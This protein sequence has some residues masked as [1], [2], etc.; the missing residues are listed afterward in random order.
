LYD[1]AGKPFGGV[2]FGTPAQVK[3]IEGW[4]LDHM[5][6]RRPLGMTDRDK[7][8]GAWNVASIKFVAKGGLVENQPK[9]LKC[10]FREDKLIDTP[11]IVKGD[12]TCTLSPRQ[13]P[14]EIDLYVDTGP[15]QG[16]GVW[17]GIYDLKGDELTLCLNSP[18]RARPTE[19]SC[20][21]GE[22]VL[23]KFKRAR[24]PEPKKLS[25]EE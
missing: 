11:F 10:E 15:A 12:C 25:M 21:K 1:Q 8:Q 20:G 5:G 18:N 24:P 14:K 22:A 9:Q 4:S 23:L 16:Q 6:V 7:L 19:F 13:N 17:K 2:Y 3:Q